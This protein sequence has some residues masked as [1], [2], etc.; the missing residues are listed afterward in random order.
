M[1]NSIKRTMCLLLMLCLVFTFM[2]MTASAALDSRVEK[3]IAWA[4]AIANDNS[5]GYSLYNRNGPDY[6][7]SSFV[8][9]AFRQGGF[10]W[11]CYIAT[12]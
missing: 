8:S 1:K 9:T 5:H 7:C 11:L 2:P 3:A 6:D 12:R 10:C 4:V